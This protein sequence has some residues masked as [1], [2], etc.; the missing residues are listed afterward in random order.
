LPLLL[1]N[2]ESSEATGTSTS[3]DEILLEKTEAD[4]EVVRDQWPSSSL[5]KARNHSHVALQNFRPL[6]RSLH[7]IVNL[8][9]F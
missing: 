9:K 2:D 7:E 4:V 6:L 3:L 1:Y 8:Q 5:V